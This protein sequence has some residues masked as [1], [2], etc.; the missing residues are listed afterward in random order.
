MLNNINT[1]VERIIAKID[2]DFNPDNSDWIPRVGAWVID[3]MSQVN[4]LR[5]VR[6]KVKL[7]VC[8]GITQTLYP[9]N[10]PN[11]IITDCNGC[12]INELKS[13]GDCNSCSSTGEIQKVKDVTPKTVD[14]INN[15]NPNY[16]PDYTM[17]VPI[18][19]NNNQHRY[20]IHNYDYSEKGK[21]RNYVLIGDNKIE[22]NFNTDF[23]YVETDM[24]ATE[25]SKTYNCELPV[26][27]NNGLL[28]EGLAAFCMWKML[29]RGYKHPV[30]NLAASQYGTNP[31]YEWKS[32]KDEIRRSL[33]IQAQGDIN[34][35]DG[36]LFKSAF[37][38]Q[39][40]G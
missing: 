30:L 24:V 3:A 8:D 39:A 31:F 23:I 15:N 35:N 2:N 6:K 20:N 28:I 18:H 19:D 21:T 4:A 29:T 25:F 32:N 14:L 13:G 10:S 36:N 17:A 37:F 22:L 38:L 33:I 16:V 9:I 11:L 26:I 27:P 34:I 5:T 1:N 7:M 12:K 40:N